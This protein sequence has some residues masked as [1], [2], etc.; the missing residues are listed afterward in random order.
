VYPNDRTGFPR[1][2][3][4]SLQAEAVERE[5]LSADVVIVGGGV[6]GLATALRL[7]QLAEGDA[8]AGREP[9]SV[10]LLEKAAEFGAHA[11]S[12]AVMDP[13]GLRALL[14]DVPEAD[15]K[16]P[17]ATRVRRDEVRWFTERRSFKAPV[18][19]SFL[20]NDGS[21]ILPV[22]RLCAWLA[23][24]VEAS[25]RVDLFTGFPA[26]RLLL[27]GERVTGVQT[28]DQGI[29]RDGAPRPNFQPGYDLTARVTVLAE[30]A[31]GSLTHHLVQRLR[32]DDG[33]N[34][35]VYATGVKE[36]WRVPAERHEE[37]LVVHNAGYPLD[38]A[39]FGGG[40]IYHMA[41]RLVSV[42]YVVGLGH[43]DPFLDPHRIFQ[44]YKRHP[45]VAA[46]LEGAELVEYGAKVIPE[47][48]YWSLP[49]LA[50]DGALIVGDSA[51]FLNGQRLK[52]I[53]LAIRGGIE[54]AEAVHAAL[55]E[56]DTSSE[57]LQEFE[58]RIHEGEVGRELYRVRNFHAANAHGVLRGLLPSAL[59]LVTRGRGLR[60]RVGEQEDWRR[61]RTVAEVYGPGARGPGST[62]PDA[63]PDGRLTFDKVTDVF[64]SGAA[65]EEDQ[66]AHLLVADLDICHGRCA[67]EYGNPC[68]YFCPANVYEFVGGRLTLNPSNCVHCK[69]C[70]IRDPY[71]IITWVVPEGA[72]GPRQKL[73]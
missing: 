47:G 35:Q 21:W 31:R 71:Q 50:V 38:T 34:P 9:P 51:G 4:D 48:G 29:G 39:T 55:R 7:A 30:G 64:H 52:G 36:I 1:A 41:D 11:V 70:D 20:H 56:G 10:M 22:S 12:G 26:A 14:P 23:E 8:A 32:L 66:P 13:V 45:F 46:L 28:R 16:I 40:W 19:P 54:A 62:P 60:N 44:R 59:Q 65:H 67:E 15:W 42:G 24:R 69:T 33:R 61:Y 6:A 5:Q 53:H 25:G 37:G 17:Y 18:V 49:R 2:A 43:E 73:T 3:Y 63:A 68:Q 72:G 27:D 57:R 58:A